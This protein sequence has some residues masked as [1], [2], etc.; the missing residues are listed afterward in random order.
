MQE[1]DLDDLIAQILK[2]RPDWTHTLV[3]CPDDLD[4]DEDELYIDDET[5]MMAFWHGETRIILDPELES[6]SVVA[7]VDE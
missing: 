3:M 6:G 4:I 2:H 5:G 7:G 1:L